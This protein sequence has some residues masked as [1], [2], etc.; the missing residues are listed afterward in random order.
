MLGSRPYASASI[1]ANEVLE[2]LVWFGLMECSIK[3]DDQ[4]RPGRIRKYRKT[5][6][7]DK[8]LIFHFTA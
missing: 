8:F 2:P 4:F 7:F 3:D 5:P 1:L 6:L